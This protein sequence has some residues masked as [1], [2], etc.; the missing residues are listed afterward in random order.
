VHAFDHAINA[1]RHAQDAGMLTAFSICVTRSFVSKQNLLKY[2]QLARDCGV[3]FVQLLEPK[4]VGHYEGKAVTLGKEQIDILEDFYLTFNFN[5]E[6]RDYPVVLYHGFH[7]RRIGCMSGG[8]R[9]LYIDSAGNV[10][11][12][13]F[14][15]TKNFHTSQIISGAI[16]IN[17]MS[18]GGCPVYEKHADEIKL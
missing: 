8:D 9:I 4:P 11:A 3:A 14:C 13:P 6:F 18:I 12:C 2:A 16:S 10:N 7:Q 1:V 17:D 15:Q 5:K